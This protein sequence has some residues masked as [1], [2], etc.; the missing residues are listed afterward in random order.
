MR[1]NSD[2]FYYK[3]QFLIYK[4]VLH[5]RNITGLQFDE[6]LSEGHVVFTK[7]LYSYSREKGKRFSTFLTVCL[8]NHF[9]SYIRDALRNKR[10][11]NK[12]IYLDSHPIHT[13]LLHDNNKHCKFLEKLG[14]LS[15]E[16]KEVVGVCLHAPEEL[17]Q[18]E[19]D[20]LYKYLRQQGW[21]KP[22]VLKT[23][24]EIKETL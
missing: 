3:Y 11:S 12:M 6:L 20:T 1:R 9:Q 18:W 16:A 10:H 2:E 22:K 15:K 24:K 8:N 21:N 17:L 13:E 14:M 4:R 19:L 5:Y 7:C 23:F